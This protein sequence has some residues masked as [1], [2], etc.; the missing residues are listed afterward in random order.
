MKS[1]DD[2]TINH[3][4][5][6]QRFY[7][8]PILKLYKCEKKICAAGYYLCKYDGYCIDSTLLCDGIK[9]C[10]YGDDEEICH[11]SKNFFFFNI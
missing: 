9:H 2:C 5:S 7:A 10:L 8:F 6:N 1:H 11:Q 3:D 4:N